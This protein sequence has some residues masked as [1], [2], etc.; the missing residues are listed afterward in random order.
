MKFS[1]TLERCAVFDGGVLGVLE[2]IPAS[3][4]DVDREE[5]NRTPAKI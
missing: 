1:D 4:L 2:K 3:S 5:V